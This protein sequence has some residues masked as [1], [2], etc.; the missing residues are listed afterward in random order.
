M[1]IITMA[2]NVFSV[3]N[4]LYLLKRSMMFAARLPMPVWY[5]TM[6]E[7]VPMNL[8]VQEIHHFAANV[9]Q[10]ADQISMNVGLPTATLL[11]AWH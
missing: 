10:A 7:L 3:T 5:T 4:V 9:A 11:A 1:T 8:I 2:H 6:V